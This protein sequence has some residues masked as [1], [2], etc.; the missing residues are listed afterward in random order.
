VIVKEAVTV[1]VVVIVG[2]HLYF[3][4]AGRGKESLLPIGVKEIRELDLPSGWSLRIRGFYPPF[5]WSQRIQGV[6]ASFKLELIN[7]R[8]YPPSN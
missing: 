5:G 6:V 3:K 4:L 7:R 1:I 2:L 8:S